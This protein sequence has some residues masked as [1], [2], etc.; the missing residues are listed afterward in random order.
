MARYDKGDKVTFTHRDGTYAIG[1]IEDVDLTDDELPYYVR[2]VNGPVTWV[3]EDSIIEVERSSSEL[4]KRIEY[5]LDAIIAH[6]GIHIE[7]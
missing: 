2:I 5:K 7:D 6:F 1:V 4:L 3:S